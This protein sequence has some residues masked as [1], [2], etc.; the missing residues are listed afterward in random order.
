MT[1][2]KIG[3]DKFFCIACDNEAEYEISQNGSFKLAFANGPHDGEITLCA[4]CAHELF[5][6]MS[7]AF[8]EV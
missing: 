5:D 1:I 3:S 4:H 7:K 8:E 6:L 2:K